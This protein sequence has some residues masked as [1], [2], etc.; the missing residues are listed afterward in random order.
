[1]KHAGGDGPGDREA[2]STCPGCGL[3]APAGDGPCDPYSGSSAACWAAFNQVAAKD[4]G[5]YRYPAVHQLIVDAY[6]SQHATFVT[7]A[8]RR[9]VLVHLVGLHLAF[10]RGLE[11]AAIGRVLGQV[12]PDKRDVPPLTPKPPPGPLTIAW[13][14]AAGDVEDHARRGRAWALSVWT[15]W[16]D[17]HGQIR[18]LAEQALARGDHAGPRREDPSR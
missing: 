1:M 4:Y 9:S 3:A 17:H 12:F 14:L 15:A 6:M 2:M 8:A 16:A 7:P 10:E 13:V 5:E 11:R 18:S